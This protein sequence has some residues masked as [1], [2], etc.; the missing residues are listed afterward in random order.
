MRSAFWKICSGLQ[1]LILEEEG[2]D[3]VEYSLLIAVLVIATIA[4]V[5]SFSVAL[6]NYY[7]YIVTNWP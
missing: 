7:Q 2:Q 4:G 1:N 3:L 6:A 5:R